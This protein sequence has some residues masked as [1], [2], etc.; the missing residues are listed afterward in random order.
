MICLK[1]YPYDSL[2]LSSYMDGTLVLHRYDNEFFLSEMQQV[3]LSAP[4][5]V[6]TFLDQLHILMAS[7]HT[8][9]LFDI[10]QVY[11]HIIEHPH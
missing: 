1:A 4:V 5:G 6:A 8:L 3:S 7:Q 9:D 10:T 11:K 2:L